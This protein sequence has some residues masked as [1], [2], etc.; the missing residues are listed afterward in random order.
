M[1]PIIFLIQGIGA[2]VFIIML[3]LLL[4]P[5][6]SRTQRTILYLY[7]IFCGLFLTIYTG[8]VGTPALLA[9]SFLILLFTPAKVRLWNCGFGAS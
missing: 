7:N 1:N 8:N 3:E 4:A 2:T 6:I 9:G 5:P